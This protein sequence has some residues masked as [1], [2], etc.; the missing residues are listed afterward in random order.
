[1]EVLL[2]KMKNINIDEL[3]FMLKELVQEENQ[4]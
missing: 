4:L 1:M 2:E 3:K